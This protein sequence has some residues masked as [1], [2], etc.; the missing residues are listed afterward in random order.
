MTRDQA[1]HRVAEPIASASLDENALRRVIV[2]RG[3]ACPMR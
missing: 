1:V 2:L 3:Q